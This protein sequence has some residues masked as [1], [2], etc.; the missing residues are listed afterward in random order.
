[1]Y[2]PQQFAESRPEVLHELM[3]S[4]PLS[5]FVVFA[6][7]ELLANHIPLLLDSTRGQYGTLRGHV[8]RS[9]PVWRHFGS[10][11]EALAIFQG[12][13]SYVTPSWY[14]AKQAD[15][16]VVPTWNYAVVH[17]Y[18]QPTAVEEPDW[19]RAHVTQL[20]S[21][22]ESQRA[23]PW[24]V[25]DAPRD[26]VEQMLKGIVGIEMTITRI[27]GKWKVSQNR[28]V[29]DRRGV[30]AGLRARATGQSEAMAALVEERIE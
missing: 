13:H 25:A 17:A 21:A 2:I 11:P 19:L 14:A 29:A 9:N 16:K 1:M 5:T 6:R 26:Y 10:T 27:Q 15:G 30:V 20:T 3:Q 7:T 12:P 18:G 22:H 28:Q 24:H 23:E 4:H 8:A